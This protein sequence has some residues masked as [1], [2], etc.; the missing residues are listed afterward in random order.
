MGQLEDLHVPGQAVGQLNDV[1]FP[2]KMWERWY[3]ISV[4]GQVVGQLKDGSVLGQLVGELRMIFL[5][6]FRLR[7]S[8]LFC[9][10]SDCE[11]AKATSCTRSDCGTSSRVM[12][13][14]LQLRALDW[15][16]SVVISRFCQ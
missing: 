1:L 7:S 9:L 15:F 11:T 2:V 12:P 8:R 3:T 14:H 6:H 10:S 16:F 5:C 4:P 13:S